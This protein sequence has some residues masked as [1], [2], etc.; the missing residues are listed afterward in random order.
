[1]PLISHV[2]PSVAEYR[3]RSS[4]RRCNTRGV[5]KTK[6]MSSQ[7]VNSPLRSKSISSMHARSGQT[8]IRDTAGASSS[9]QAANVGRQLKGWRGPSALRRP[10]HGGC[11]P[12]LKVAPPALSCL[13]KPRNSSTLKQAG[14]VNPKLKIRLVR[15]RVS[16]MCQAPNSNTNSNL[17]TRVR[18]ALFS[19][20]WWLRLPHLGYAASWL[21]RHRCRPNRSIK[22][23][24]PGKPGHAAYL[25]R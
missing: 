11:L 8:A 1:M 2:R 21:L 22:R 15:R 7:F 14:K 9:S 24:C 20:I 12:E 18:P 5:A 3:F 23:T 13:Q 6:S 19:A 17:S 16:A 25:K 10:A 4:A